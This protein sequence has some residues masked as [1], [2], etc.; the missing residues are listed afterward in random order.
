ML[1]TSRGS[2]HNHAASMWQLLVC[3]QHVFHLPVRMMFLAV[4][5]FLLCMLMPFVLW[6]KWHDCCSLMTE[7]FCDSAPQMPGSLFLQSIK[8]PTFNML[9]L[10][11]IA[12]LYVYPGGNALP[13]VDNSLIMN[14]LALA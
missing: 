8:Y 9:M 4:N 1:S 5:H 11:L 14:T 13:D 6:Q 2:G 3:G 12:A 7:L 10:C